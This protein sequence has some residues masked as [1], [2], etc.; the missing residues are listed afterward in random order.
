MTT[1]K[2]QQALET[3]AQARAKKIEEQY[4][5]DKALFMKKT[6]EGAMAENGN[7]WQKDDKKRIYFNRFNLFYDYETEAIEAIDAR[8]PMDYENFENKIVKSIL[9]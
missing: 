6:L 5:G 2:I 9:L 4:N 1:S 7:V 3:K 8:E